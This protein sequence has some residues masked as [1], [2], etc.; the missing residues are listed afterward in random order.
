MT[1][2]IG[3]VQVKGGAVRSTVRLIRHECIHK[4]IR[5]K[6]A[7]QDCSVTDMIAKLLQQEF[8]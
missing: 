2:I 6:A 1:K 4:K 8:K 7:E 3:L 5:M